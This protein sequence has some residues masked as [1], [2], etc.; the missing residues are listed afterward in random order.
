MPESTRAPD[1]MLALVPIDAVPA[2]AGWLGPSERQRLAGFGSG[3]RRAQFLAGH[4]LARQLAASFAGGAPADWQFVVAG[5][6]RRELV[7][8]D[9]RRLCLSL[10]HSGTRVA[11]A[12]ADRPIGLD[13]E[14]NGEPRDW[15][16]LAGRLFAPA[17]AARVQ[18]AGP[19]Q[20]A[21]RFREAWALHEARAKQ[22]GRGL[23]REA[24]KHLELNPSDAAEAHALAWELEGGCLA[25]AARPGATP[26]FAPG[27]PAPPVPLRGWRYEAAGPG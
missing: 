7:H 27:Y 22:D 14:A 5:D 6:Q 17:T 19:G 24:M 15:P 11:A 18:A 12:V 25:L 9:G 23:Q 21:T 3:A 13:L 16:S 4:V 20:W 2:E 1:V 10:S 8:P 26:G